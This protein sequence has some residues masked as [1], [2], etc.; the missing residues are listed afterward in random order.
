MA[1]KRTT[2][3]KKRVLRSATNKNI[4]FLVDKLPELKKPDAT[5]ASIHPK[6]KVKFV[7]SSSI[8][9]E[10]DTTIHTHTLPNKINNIS[11]AGSDTD[12]DQGWN[13]SPALPSS[14]P[15]I[16]TY[17][18]RITIDQL[19]EDWEID[20]QGNLDGDDMRTDLQELPVSTREDFG[21][22]GCTCG[23]AE[24]AEKYKKLYES[25]RKAVL[26]NKQIEGTHNDSGTQVQ[27]EKH[28]TLIKDNAK[29][30]AQNAKLQEA[31][32]SKLL[33]QPE[34][35]F[36]DVDGDFLDADTIRQLSVEADTDYLFVK[37]LMM[38]LWPEGFVGRS[39]T[40]RPSNNPSGRSKLA[41]TAPNE[42]ATHQTESNGI[43]N[44]TEKTPNTIDNFGEKTQTSKRPLEKEKVEFV[45]SCIYNRRLFLRDDGYTAQVHSKAGTSLM[46]RVIANSVRKG[47]KQ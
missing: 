35:P 7:Q 15:L 38:R 37:F 26:E 8:D 28:T 21:T 13:G 9:L 17:R 32:T 24:E 25:L 14:K 11:S 6:K 36:K 18:R 45:L 39:V 31:L 34:V 30:T 16:R 10:D 19:M 1:R 12:S 20:D 44:F 3:A 41:K 46:T 5:A 40:G 23:K 4:Q 29:L 33:P 2:A 22:V 42:N 47:A 43:E 27:D